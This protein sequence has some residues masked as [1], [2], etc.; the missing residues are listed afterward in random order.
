MT[1]PTRSH[2]LAACKAPCFCSISL[3]GAKTPRL[4]GPKSSFL[5]LDLSSTAYL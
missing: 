3:L 5:L 1:S 4:S 2:L